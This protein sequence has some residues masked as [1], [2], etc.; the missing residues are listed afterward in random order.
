GKPSGPI[1]LA[2]WSG[3]PVALLARHGEG[4]MLSPSAVPYRA[5]I[6]ALKSLGVT[7]IIASGAVG[8][9]KEKIQP[10]HLVVPDQVIDK[11]FGRESSFFADHLAVHAEFSHPFCPHLRRL[12]LDCADQVD[13]SVHDGGTYVCMEGPQF[14]T[15][16]ESR[17]HIAWGGDLI[18]MTCMPEAKLAREAQICYALL[19]LPSDYDCWREHDPGLSKL[20]LLNEIIANLKQVSEYGTRLIQAAI[21]RAGELVEIDCPD[22]KALELAIWS[23]KQQIPKKVRQELQLLLGEYL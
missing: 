22:R 16:A 21:S 17:M 10:R 5:N 23:D 12:L 7:H 8:S 20:E 2:Q 6:Y 11:T 15:Q 14:S 13:T 1:T 4:H 19:A 3:V 18:G 9:L